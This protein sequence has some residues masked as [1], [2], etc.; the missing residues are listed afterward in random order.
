MEEPVGERVG[1]QAATVLFGWVAGVAEY[2]TYCR[3]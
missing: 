2:V 1:L 3:I